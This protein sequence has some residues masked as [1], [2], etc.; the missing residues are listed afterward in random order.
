MKGK[1]RLICKTNNTYFAQFLTVYFYGLPNE[2]VVVLY[3]REKE[4]NTNRKSLEWVVASH[5]DFRYDYE[6]DTII[7][8]ENRAC[9]FEEFI[10]FIDKQ[11]QHI[12]PLQTFGEFYSLLDAEQFYNSGAQK[13][14]YNLEPVRATMNY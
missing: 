6:S 12:Q 10:D 13:M 3:T 5:L 11:E 2:K 1:A 8:K 9:D 4:G 14:L 7:D